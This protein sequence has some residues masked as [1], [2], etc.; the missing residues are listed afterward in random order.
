MLPNEK[1]DKTEKESSDSQVDIILEKLL[2]AK[3]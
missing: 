3:T 2:E 1:T